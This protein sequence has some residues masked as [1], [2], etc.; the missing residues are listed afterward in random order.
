MMD[1]VLVGIGEDC[2]S[3]VDQ[4]INEL[5]E[6][7]RIKA[8]I[9]DRDERY[10]ELADRSFPQKTI[11]DLPDMPFDKLFICSRNCIMEESVN[12]G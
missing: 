4:A 9:F 1:I 2:V 10:R 11:E 3:I 12:K 5:R 8:I 7:N 6:E